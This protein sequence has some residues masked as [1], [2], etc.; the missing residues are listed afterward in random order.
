MP[1]LADL[2]AAERRMTAAEYDDLHRRG[3]RPEVIDFLSDRGFREAGEIRHDDG[4][5]SPTFLRQ[6]TMPHLHIAVHPGDSLDDLLSAIYDMAW[7]D[8]AN[9]IANSFNNFLDRVRRPRPPTETERF[10]DARLS[11]LEKKF[12]ENA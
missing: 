12:Q 1:S 8:G 5:T 9:H 6:T 3:Y 7:T 4:T 2:I 10:H 11:A